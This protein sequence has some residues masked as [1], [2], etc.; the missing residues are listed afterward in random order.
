MLML[1]KVFRQN[2]VSINR[3]LYATHQFDGRKDFQYQELRFDN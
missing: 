1:I 3:Y 2:Q